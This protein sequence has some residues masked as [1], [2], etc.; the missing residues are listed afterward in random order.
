M[1]ILLSNDDGIFAEGLKALKNTLSPLGEIYIVAPDRERSATGH[2]I[3]MHAPLRPKQISMDNIKAA[4]AVDGTPA[5][6]VKL[7]IEALLPGPPDILVSGINWGPNLGTDVL[8][9]GTVSAAIEGLINGIPSVAISLATHNEPDFSQAT[10]FIRKIVL[11]IMKHGL[12]ED[13]LCNINIPEGMPKGVKVTSLGRRKYENVFHKRSDP[14][15]QPY[16]WMG[17]EPRD[18]IPQNQCDGFITD[19]EAIKKGYIS[20][21][22]IHFDLTDYKSLKKL[23]QWFDAK[24]IE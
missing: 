20:V 21:T 5:D 2:G 15:G 10:E 3:T 8:Y 14:R 19:I 11:K 9:S 6:C 24:E 23:C 18:E 17:G 7:G 13:C 22:P 1:R 4:W 16:Y 12:P